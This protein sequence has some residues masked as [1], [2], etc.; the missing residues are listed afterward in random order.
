MRGC[1]GTFA[2]TTPNVAQEIIRNAVCAASQDPRFAPVT[3]EELPEI[4]YSVD[5]LSPP[6][7]VS[8]SGALNCK[9]YGVIV[10]CGRRRGL[11]LPDLEGVDTVADQLS[12]ARRKAGIGQDEAVEIECF[13]VK[14]YK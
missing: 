8:E 11:L 5:I 2:P 9:R 10:T 14:R 4:E 13:E 6:E 3:P 12:I 7:P 1:I